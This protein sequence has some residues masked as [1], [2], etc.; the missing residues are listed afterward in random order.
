MKT[1]KEGLHSRAAYNF[2]VVAFWLNCEIS[3]NYKMQ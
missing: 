3:A 2:F 1:F